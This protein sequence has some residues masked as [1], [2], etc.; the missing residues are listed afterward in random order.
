MSVRRRGNGLTA[1]SYVLLIDVDPGLA[2]QLLAALASAGIAA[3]MTPSDGSAARSAPRLELHLPTRPL[4]AVHVDSTRR[5][6]AR[7]VL[8]ATVPDLTAGLPTVEEEDQFAALI[9]AWNDEPETHDWPAAEDLEHSPEQDAPD[10]PPAGP[11]RRRRTDLPAPDPD[12]ASGP[13][14]SGDTASGATDD[15]TKDAAAP[16]SDAPRSEADAGATNRPSLDKP[17]PPDTPTTPA[18][19]GAFAAPSGPTADEH[20]VPP[21]LPPLPPSHP[22]TKWGL[23][24]LG[25]GLLLLIFPTLLGLEHS[26]GVDFVGVFC[27]IGA[28]GLLVSRL[29]NRSTDEYEG[30]DDGAVV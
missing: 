7:R 18:D 20:Y 21:P 23:V 13:T 29:S 8:E 2:E 28:V 26:T 1:E 25:L 17:A 3:Y 14:K 30:P 5:P 24:A 19:D 16:E 4:D 11:P 6:A 10:A 12:T 9:A 27:I 22:V 15:P